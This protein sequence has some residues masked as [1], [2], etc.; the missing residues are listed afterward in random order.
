LNFLHHHTK[1]L[2]FS[3]SSKLYF[4]LSVLRVLSAAGGEWIPWFFYLSVI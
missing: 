1:F 3:A 2:L 4:F